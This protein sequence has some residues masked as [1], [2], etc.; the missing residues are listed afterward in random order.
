[1]PPNM[2]CCC[3]V[4][5]PAKLSKNPAH[6][7][8]YFIDVPDLLRRPPPS[9]YAPKAKPLYSNFSLEIFCTSEFIG[10]LSILVSLFSPKEEVV[11]NFA[12]NKIVGQKKMRIIMIIHLMKALYCPIFYALWRQFN[13][14]IRRLNYGVDW[15]RGTRLS[16]AYI[17]TRKYQI[18]PKEETLNKKYWVL[19]ARRGGGCR[20]SPKWLYEKLRVWQKLFLE[21]PSPTKSDSWK[22]KK[23]QMMMW[24]GEDIYAIPK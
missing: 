5:K 23:V 17:Q 21:C 6:F 2:P 18:P 15:N 12:A 13:L 8:W 7:Y 20:I 3:E 19:P 14:I 16:I 11:G 9:N 24:Q 4:G 22:I 1:M 10:G